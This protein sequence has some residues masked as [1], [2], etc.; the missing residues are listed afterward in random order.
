MATWCSESICRIGAGLVHHVVIIPGALSLLPLR[1]VAVGRA[2][3]ILPIDRLCTRFSGFLFL[4]FFRLLVPTSCLVIIF[5]VESKE[6][7][8]EWAI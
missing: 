5:K 1:G 7:E 8:L 6:L 4:Q 2:P 3:T